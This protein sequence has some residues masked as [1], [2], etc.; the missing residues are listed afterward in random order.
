MVGRRAAAADAGLER[1]AQ[2]LRPV[3]HAAGAASPP[4]R[5]TRACRWYTPTTAATCAGPQ[6]HLRAST[7]ATRTGPSRNSGVP[8]GTARTPTASRASGRSPATSASAATP[9]T[10]CSTLLRRAA[11]LPR[12]RRQDG[13]R[14]RHGLRRPRRRPR[15]RRREAGHQV[16]ARVLPRHGRRRLH[17]PLRRPPLLHLRRRPTTIPG[18]AASS[19]TTTR[20]APGAL[21]AWSGDYDPGIEGHGT[22]TASTS[23][24]RASSTAR[25]RRSPTCPAR[26][27]L[28]GRRHR[29]RAE[30]QARPVRRHL[31]RL[32][33]LDPDRLPALDRGRHRRHLELLRQLRGRQRRLRRRQPGGRHLHNGSATTPLFSTG[34]GA[35]G[36]GTTTRAAPVAGIKVGASTQFGGTGWDSIGSYR[37]GRRQRRDRCGRTAGPGA[38]GAPASTSSPTAPTRR[39]TRR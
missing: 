17:R 27:A 21:L 32:R 16:L 1:L 37:P 10:T 34:N 12:R 18:G 28:P 11:R 14:L 38:T 36:Y 19:A 39:A 9:T 4:A 7:F 35:P 2:G 26:R 25:R 33:H 15:L 29:R 8:A 30:G 23:S 31:L 13:R 22:L 5:S 24:A 20:R 6:R 3:R